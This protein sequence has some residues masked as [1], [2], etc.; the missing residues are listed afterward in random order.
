M[1]E[2][3]SRRGGARPGSGRPKGSATAKTRAIADKAAAEGLTPLEYLLKVLRDES[4]E[5]A[6]RMDAA[7]SA[8]PYIHPRLSSVEAKVETEVRRKVR[9]IRR[10]V[11]RNPDHTDTG[12]VPTVTH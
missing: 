12:G 4:Q 1:T 10:E 8:A 11:I 7:K 2:T 3:K 5:Q 9:T 6:V